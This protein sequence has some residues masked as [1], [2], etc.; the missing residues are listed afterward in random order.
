LQALKL[1]FCKISFLC[2]LYD[3]SSAIRQSENGSGEP[4]ETSLLAKSECSQNRCHHP[5]DTINHIVTFHDFKNDHERHDYG[6]NFDKVDNNFLAR[7]NFHYPTTTFID[8]EDLEVQKFIHKFK[9]N[10]YVEPSEYAFKGFDMT[11]D[12][13]LRLATFSDVGGAFDGGISER[14]SCKF[15]YTKNP[16]KGFENKGVYLVKYDGLHLVN[17]EKELKL[18]KE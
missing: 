15:H 17:V 14:M 2:F 10:N 5:N 6:K 12:A 1:V 4:H 7:V 3:D 9:T 13:L 8:Y 16:N 11:Y 18:E